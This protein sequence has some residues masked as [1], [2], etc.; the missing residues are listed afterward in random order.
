MPP[1]RAVAIIADTPVLRTAV[2]L[3]GLVSRA[4][5]SAVAVACACAVLPSIAGGTSTT[6]VSGS[7]EPRVA[8]GDVVVSFRLPERDWHVGNVL[9]VQ[10]PDH[11][12][13]LRL[14]RLRGVD[15]SGRLVLQ[16]DANP[17]PDSTHVARSAV[18]GVAMVRVPMLGV[19]L[20]LARQ[21]RSVELVLLSAV[22]LAFVGLVRLDQLIDPELRRTGRQRHGGR[23]GLGVLAA[24][25]LVVPTASPPS[26]GAALSALVSPPTSSLGTASCFGAFTPVDSPT[27]SYSYFQVTGS[28]V[29]DDSGQGHDGQL[30]GT[31]SR[32][33]GCAAGDQAL[34]LDGSAGGIA[35]YAT[36]TA[37]T[38]A[39]TIEFWVKTT[40][41]NGVLAD[42]GSSSSGNSSS[43]A[44]VVS[45][46]S[47]SIAYNGSSGN[48]VANG[49]WHLVDLVLN[50]SESRL[51][52]D[53]VGGGSVFSSAPPAFTG[54]WRFGGDAGSYITGSMDNTAVYP[55]A[56]TAS[57]I[58]AH[59]N[60]GH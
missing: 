39:L 13:R 28:T 59:K 33:G 55:S 22:L 4:S 7:M 46:S 20:V 25:A 51:Y 3:L 6:V 42:I 38:S 45:V 26:A 41:Q 11:E 19:P 12:G 40:S 56:L 48:T 34:A 1:S 47:G 27:F 30:R 50:G 53:A 2:F 57:Q 37:T 49:S 32:S 15:A 14:H 44:R 60:R 21:G 52:V 54:Y 18:L 8:V 9:L 17:H 35:T 16:G 58:T 43:T 36:A 5:L 29:A 23:S 31:A 10:D 24:A